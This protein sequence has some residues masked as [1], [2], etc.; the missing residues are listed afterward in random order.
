MN[1]RK[2]TIIVLLVAV[3]LCGF[4]QDIPQHISYTRIYEFLDEL[5]TDNIIELNSAIKPYSRTFI[6]ER[7]NEALWQSDKLNNR[8]RKELDFYLNEYALENN[9]LPDSKITLLKNEK[10]KLALLQPAFHYQDSLFR[11]RITP[12][13]G[14]NISVNSNGRIIKRWIGAEFQAMIGKHLS[15]YGSLRDIS[16][17]GD[18]LSSYKYLNLQPGYEYKEATYGG[19]YSDSRGGIKLSNSW[20]SIGLVKDNVVWGDNFHGSNILSGRAPSFP[21]I[22]LRLQPVKWFELNYFHAWLVSNVVDSTY[23]YIENDTRIWYRQT[24]KFMAANMFTFTPVP[25]LKISVGNSIIY[26]ERSVQAAY[27]IPIAFYKSMDH[28]LT[29]GIGTENQNSQMFMNISSR[30]IKHLHLYGSVYVD[31]F[32]FDRLKP[33][34]AEAN[35]I[36]YKL[37][38]N[39][40]NFPVNNLSFTVEFTRSNILNYKHS[41]AAISYSSNGYNLGHYMGDNAQELYLALQYKPFRGIDLKLSYTDARKGNEYDYLRRGTYNGITGTVSDIIKQPSLGDVIWTNKALNFS[42]TYEVFNNVYAVLQAEYSNI[43]SYEPSGA[44]VYGERRMTATETL[45]YF[46]PAFLQGKNLTLSAGLSFGF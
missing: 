32:N 9:H 28:T 22:T 20:G 23:S 43:Q 26:A 4:A 8:Q 17:N 12:I 13:L 16:N 27:L 15:V 3:S 5:A 21:M 7:L 10:L 31:E 11:A 36:S 33:G 18:T 34:N 44:A 24:N 19:D 46:T 25:R 2:L 14:M 6:A 45:N 40:S 30:N 41:I 29:K 39:V 38:A 1:M 37:G 42:G 35:P